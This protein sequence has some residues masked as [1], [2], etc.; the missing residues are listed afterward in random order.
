MP[1]VEQFQT[2]ESARGVLTEVRDVLWSA[3]GKSFS[4]EDWEH[5]LGGHHLVVRDHDRIVAHAAVVG[6][7]LQVGRQDFDAGY[8]EGVATRPEHQRLGH[9]TAV[10][11]AVNDVLR[12][13]FDLGALSTSQQEFYSGLGWDAWRGPCYV[14]QGA[15][16]VRTADE[17]AGLMV[18]RFGSSASVDLSLPIACETRIGDDW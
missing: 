12:E 9:G 1:V 4:E 14:I 3:F 17:D 13:Q 18:L 6:R 5:S 10:M 8:V 11:R 16:R 15:E 2:S 7:R